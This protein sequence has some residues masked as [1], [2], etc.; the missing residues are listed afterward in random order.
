MVCALVCTLVTIRFWQKG[1][2]GLWF[3]AYVWLNNR[4]MAYIEGKVFG[5]PKPP[6]DG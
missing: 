4:M 3:L 1:G 5:N 6:A 2:W